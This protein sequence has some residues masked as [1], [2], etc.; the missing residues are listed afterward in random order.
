VAGFYRPPG[1]TTIGTAAQFTAA[2][3]WNDQT[4]ACVAPPDGDLPVS[5]LA[6]VM[7]NLGA[8][9]PYTAFPQVPRVYT[10][11]D[12]IDRVKNGNPIYP[13]TPWR[14]VGASSSD[15][16]DAVSLEAG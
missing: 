10:G 12:F 14:F 5:D 1:L 11:G 2:W 3:A 15:K 8:T 4:G 13:P 7:L 6:V 16:T 9:N